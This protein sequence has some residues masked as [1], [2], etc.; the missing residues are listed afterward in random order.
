VLDLLCWYNIHGQTPVGTYFSTENTIARTEWQNNFEWLSCLTNFKAWFILP[1][2]KATLEHHTK[3]DD[4]D[5]NIVEI[6]VWRVSVTEHTPHGF[7][8]SLVYIVEGVRVVGYDNERG[9]GDHRHIV[10]VEQPYQ[11]HGISGLFSDFKADM[12]ALKRGKHES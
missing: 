4:S 12:D 6:K 10:D 2:M 7:K 9:K 5:G 11:Y 3:Y 8:Y 1:N